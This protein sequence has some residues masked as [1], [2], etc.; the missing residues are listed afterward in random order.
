MKIQ[1]I[2]LIGSGRVATQLGLALAAKHKNIVQVYSRHLESA[3][4]LSARVDAVAIDALS[5][6]S[7][8]SDLYIISVVD[9]AIAEVAAKLRF[10]G[11]IVAHTSGSVPMQVLDGYDWKS[12][13]IYPL[14]TFAKDK[15]VDFKNIPICIEAADAETET[16]LEVLAREL[17]GDVRKVNSEQRMMIH[18]AA[19]FANNFTNFM[20]VMSQELL[21]KSDLSFDILLPL[22]RETT[23][24]LNHKF[25]KEAQ[26]GPAARGDN[27]VIRKHLKILEDQE[28]KKIIYQHISKYIVDY[29]KNKD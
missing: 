11:K 29:Y 23:D 18:V 17:S 6:L 9:D 2:T 21:E 24:K 26:T 20:Y 10:S 25:P 19:V 12:A 7:S 27:E 28:G 4:Q 16:H 22:I 14:Q 8:D 13:V 1:K 3:R 5:Q 15:N